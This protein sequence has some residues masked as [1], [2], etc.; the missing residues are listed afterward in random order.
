MV[1]YG[2]IGDKIDELSKALV[3]ASNAAIVI[4]IAIFGFKMMAGGLQNLRREAFFV[5]AITRT[6]E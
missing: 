4:Y 1:S 6:K 2:V 5:I 3:G